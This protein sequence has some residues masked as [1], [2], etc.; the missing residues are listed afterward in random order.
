MTQY[1]QTSRSFSKTNVETVKMTYRTVS[2][3]S[4]VSKIF[5]KNMNIH[6]SIYFE[7]SV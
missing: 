1:V 6:F 5:E 7:D 2:I 3:L 4:V